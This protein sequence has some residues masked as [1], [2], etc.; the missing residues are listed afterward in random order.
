MKPEVWRRVEELCQQALDLDESRRAEFLQSACGGDDELRH[1]VESLLAHEK[2][3]EHFIESP[4]LEVAGKLAAQELP[5][6]SGTNLIGITVS[7]YRVIEKLGGGGMGVVYK[8]RDTQLGRFVALKFLPD[9]VAQDPQALSRF[10]LEAKA[11]S[12]L[13]H[14]NICTIHEMGKHGGRSFIVMEYLEGM[15]LKHRMAGHPLETDLILSLAIEITDALEAAHAAGIVHRDI[16]PAN[17]FVTK[18]GHA[19]ILDFGLAKVLP[20]GS[21]ASASRQTLTV[22]NEHLTSPG[23]AIGTV[24]YMSPEQVRA[25]ELDARTDLFSFGAV[26]YEM[27]TGTLPFRGE[28]LGVIFIAILERAPIPVTRLNPDVPIELEG[29][30]NKCLE[31]DRQ[32]RYQHASELRNDLKVIAPGT[33]VSV[34]VATSTTDI[35]RRAYGRRAKALALGLVLA[36][37]L[38]GT[39]S[40]K[41]VRE[42]LLGH[43]S[44][45]HV[46]SL[47]VLPLANLSGDPGQDFFADGMTEALITDLGKISALRVISR[48]SVVQYKGT[49]K[50]LPE[51]A[52]ELNVDA[53]IEGTVSRA[54]NHFRITANLVQANPEKH[55]W[56]ES[57]ESEVGDVLALQGQVAQAVAREVQV[58]LTPEEQKLLGSARPVNPKAHDDY[59][60]GRYLC[61]R[62]TREGAEK[63]MQYF[64]QAVEEAPSD[65][66]G[67]AGLAECYALSTWGGDLFP[68]DLSPSEI[69]PSAREAAQKALQL[70]DG[71]AEAHMTLAV[72]MILDWNWTGAE[73]EFK[74][75][76]ELN[77]SYSVAHVYY[78]HYLAAVGRFDES[79][80]EAR[81]GLELDPLSQFTKDWAEWAFYLAHRYDLSIEA[82]RKSLELAPEF[83]WPHFDLGQVYVATGRTDEAIQ[84]FMKAEELFGMSQDKLTE[85]R[86]AYRQSGEKGY[87]RK[88]LELCQEASKQPRMSASVSGYGHC[89]YAENQ[90]LAWMQTR[91]GETDAA[92]KSL[93][94]AYTKREGYLIYVKVDARWDSI[95]SDAR[96]QSLLRRMGLQN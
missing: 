70:D 76:I 77:S 13:N 26:L 73:R 23:S 19:K 68:G 9:D 90:D 12:A 87:W 50:P 3:A 20:S 37:V 59:L 17:I 62:D 10:Q 30:I 22:E 89:D 64:K 57:Y 28:S 91:L 4:A 65:P 32:L 1:E 63:A 58:K 75:A 56:A 78:A 81:R 5:K 72:E 35:E 15:T 45:L 61:S 85:L 33:P 46:N 55:L 82:S 54:G 34:P 66:L 39:L 53:L 95:R 86:T 94:I 49:K 93:E 11:A 80:A 38:I 21:A 16:K 7:H 8:A 29:I 36:V 52:R 43:S 14:P 92:F 69:M 48:T 67:Y 74:R 47:A 96:F 31:K 41:K 83:P 24:A 79:I 27:A 71:L 88:T 51:I 84:E 44:P 2:K 25:K 18:R 60:K 42:R 40:L 6:D